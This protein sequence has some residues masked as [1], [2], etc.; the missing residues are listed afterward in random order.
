MSIKYTIAV[1]EDGAVTGTSSEETILEQVVTGVTIPFGITAASNEV[2]S[3]KTAA[4]A[5]LGFGIG[6]FLLGEALGHKRDRAGS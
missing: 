5:T 4:Y 2:V 3:K 6:G 1:A